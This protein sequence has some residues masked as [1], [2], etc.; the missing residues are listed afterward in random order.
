LPKLRNI[1]AQSGLRLLQ[2]NASLETVVACT[3]AFVYT[4][5]LAPP[6]PFRLVYIRTRTVC[7]GR[8]RCPIGLRA[9]QCTHHRR[10]PYMRRHL[11]PVQRLA[12]AG[13]NF[14]SDRARVRTSGG[15]GRAGVVCAAHL[16]GG[17]HRKVRRERLRVRG[18]HDTDMALHGG[19]S[20]PAARGT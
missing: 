3:D 15:Y 5:L 2:L 1:N 13:D 19:V 6:L 7:A 8:A 12:R 17:V 16:R 9:T 20:G 18:A 11:L 10:V 4:N 14:D